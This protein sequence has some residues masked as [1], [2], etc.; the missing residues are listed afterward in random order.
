V[1]LYSD[2]LKSFGARPSDYQGACWQGPWRQWVFHPVWSYAWRAQEEMDFLRF[3]QDDLEIVREAV[4]RGAWNYLKTQQAALRDKYHRPPAHWR[5][6]ESLPMHNEVTTVISGGT[7]VAQPECPYPNYSSAWRA[8][9]RNLNSHEMMI[10]AIA[11]R[12]YHRQ[13]G[14]MPGELAALVPAYLKAVPRDIVDG[15]PLRYRLNADGSF[16]LYSI[17][18]DAKDDGGDKRPP[19]ASSSGSLPGFSSGR[20]WV[21]PQLAAAVE[22]SKP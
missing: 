19:V 4:Q 3:S 6:Y 9:A 8:T 13:H 10:T 17:G 1:D 14:R 18:E 12:R 15:Q 5:F 2:I 20:D 7:P 11:L 21:W 22:P 16:T